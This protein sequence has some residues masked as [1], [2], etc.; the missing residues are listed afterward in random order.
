M[1][2]WLLKSVFILWLI[3]LPIS[4]SSAWFTRQFDLLTTVKT[5]WGNSTVYSTNSYFRINSNNWTLYTSYL[6]TSKPVFYT[7]YGDSSSKRFWLFY[8]DNNWLPYIYS[9]AK[10][11]SWELNLQWN[12]TKYSLCN[13]ISSVPTD[14]AWDSWPSS[15]TTYDIWDSFNSFLVDFFSSIV[16]SDKY[17]YRTNYWVSSNSYVESQFNICF[18]NSSL[19]QSLC[20]TAN[21]RAWP[22][23]WNFTNTQLVNSVWYLSTLDFASLNIWEYK[24]WWNWGSFPLPDYSVWSWRQLRNYEVLM[25]FEYMWLSK[26]YCYWW[27]DIDNIFLASE[28]FSDFSGYSFWN[29]AS[30]FDL[31]NSYWWGLSMKPFLSTYYQSFLNSQLSNF[32]NKSKAL[33]MFFQQ[34]QSANDREWGS[35]KLNDLMDYCDLYFNL[36]NN[37]RENDWDIYTWNSQNAINSYQLNRKIP[38]GGFTN[39]WVLFNWTWF[40][41]AD[42][43]FWR[44]TN[45]FQS[46]VNWVEGTFPPMIPSYIV[47]FMLAIILIRI[48]SH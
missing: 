15:C 40:S 4:F 30:I 23:I 39:T 8:W 26:E 44:L 5:V 14:S 24:P 16:P 18:S 10:N 48:I 19:E 12:F 20:F 2:K 21:W 17:Y 1:I 3:L 41:S 9:Y 32:H 42:E 45:L 46:S 31:Y 38:E 47:A 22:N 28:Q 36:K 7:Y 37:N 33:L 11:G 29:G 34:Y 27:F 43:F 25:W 13:Y 6:W 35:F